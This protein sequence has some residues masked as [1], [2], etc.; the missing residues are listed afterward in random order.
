MKSN[1]VISSASAL[2]L[3]A[4]LANANQKLHDHVQALHKR[5]H[6][7]HARSAP[8]TAEH[9]V[10]LRAPSPE[11]AAPEIEKRDGQCQ[12]PYGAGLVPVAPGG[13]NAGWAMSPDEPCKPGNYCPYACPPGQ[14]MAQWD[15][16][17]TS[18]SYPKS[19]VSSCSSGYECADISRTVGCS[20]TTTV[21]SRS[22]SPINPTVCQPKP[23]SESSTKL[24]RSFLS[25]RRCSL[26]MKLCLSRPK[27]G[28]AQPLPT[29]TPATGARRL[30]TTTSTLLE[31]AP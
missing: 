13:M 1:T 6:E 9:G 18:Y 25:A 14:V 29:L 26:A 16:S 17:A 4:S 10:E 22:L 19:M 3:L 30:R 15:P 7:Q 21:K 8:E 24:A 2:L 23:T 27:S 5:H 11:T 20:V 12:F 31:S 28:E